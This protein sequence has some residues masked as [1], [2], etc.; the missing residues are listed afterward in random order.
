MIRAP[1]D[2]R[3][4]SY[5]NTFKD[6][7]ELKTYYTTFCVD[8]DKE[9]EY[10]LTASEWHLVQLTIAFLQPFKEATKRY[11]GDYVTLDK[12]QLIMDALAAHFKEQKDL[13]R[14]NTSFSESI[15]IAWYAFDK[16]YQLI[17]ET[18]AYT[19]AILLHPSYRK[20][21]LQTAWHK[22]W[23]SPGVE[24]AREIWQQYKDNDNNT[25][26]TTDLSH[27]TQYER[28]CY[29]IQQRQQRVKGMSDEFERF[30]IAPP[31][32]IDTPALNWWLQ[33]Q[34][35]TSYPRLSRMAIDTLSAVAMSAE[36]ERVF[37]AARRTIPWTRAR[38]ESTIIEQLECLKHWQKSGLISG[39]YVMATDSDS[40]DEQHPLERQE[41]EQPS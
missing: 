7:L 4:N 8:F 24:R 18:G 25:S 40:D 35:R 37:S 21:Y 27:M 26:Q 36:S 15:V 39:D 9:D 16:Y 13:H 5:L 34:Q 30:I 2:M 14:G 29:E 10:Q 22:D 33:H 11:K 1:N 17:D 31:V 23:V 20:G 3:W 28:Y 6:A 32:L 41:G 19:A 12:V 38:L